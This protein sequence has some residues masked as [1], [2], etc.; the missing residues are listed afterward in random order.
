[1]PDKPGTYDVW[2]DTCCGG[3]ENPVMHGRIVIE[4]ANAT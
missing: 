2:C 1:V 3:E 4:P